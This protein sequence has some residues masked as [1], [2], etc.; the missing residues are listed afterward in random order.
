[1]NW[2][3][4]IAT[5]CCVDR[6]VLEVLDAIEASGI[7]GVEFGAPPRHFS[8]S[9]PAQLGAIEADRVAAWAA[10]SMHAPFGGMYEL[11][12]P[13]EQRRDRAVTALTETSVALK[14][15]GGRVLVV[16]PTDIERAHHDVERRLADAASSL[17]E[18]VHGAARLGI[19]V[20]IESPLPHLIGGHPDEFAWI[21]NH[22][23]PEARVCLDTGHAWLG[24][25]W[26]RFLALTHDRLAHVHVRDNRG[27]YD[28]QLP[29][30]DGVLPWREIRDSLADARYSGWLVLERACP[31]EPLPSYFARAREH[32]ERLFNGAT[33]V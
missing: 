19:V 31:T 32:A 10:V 14:Q 29:P 15:L 25:H 9:D 20:A 11:S 7:A 28:D 13:N 4:A 6:P 22:V 27:H 1:M 18:V 26:R 12:D 2:P 33:L 16:H 21:V 8:P 23:G 3:V 17:R 30:G 24:G 5:G